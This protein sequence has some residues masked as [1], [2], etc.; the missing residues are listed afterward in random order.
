MFS[1][2]SEFYLNGKIEAGGHRRERAMQAFVFY[3]YL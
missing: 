2:T 1:L 3:L